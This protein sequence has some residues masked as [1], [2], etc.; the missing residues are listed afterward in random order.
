MRP[1]G[2]AR[3]LADALGAQDP[4]VLAEFERQTGGP[5][6][7]AGAAPCPGASGCTGCAIGCLVGSNGCAVLAG[8]RADPDGDRWR[9]RA[10]APDRPAEFGTAGAIVVLVAFGLLNTL[11]LAA[12]VEAITRTGNMRYGLAFF[13]RLISDYLG[14]SG[15]L[16]VM[17]VLFGLEAASFVICLVGLGTIIGAATGLPVV[18]CAAALFAVNVVILWR[19]SLDVTVAVRWHSAS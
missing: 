7:A 18:A 19:D 13:G 8:V 4:T 14:R 3:S 1:A 15:N 5:L 10:G 17:P 12:L 11:T 2:Q 16:A 6:A 9:W